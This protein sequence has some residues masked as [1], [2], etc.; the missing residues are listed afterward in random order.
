MEWIEVYKKEVFDGTNTTEWVDY[1]LVWR[2]FILVKMTVNSDK[3]YVFTES[4]KKYNDR[5]FS[6][7][8]LFLGRTDIEQVK[9]EIIKLFN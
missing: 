7:M 3:V 9:E 5:E 1:V 8:K 4:I 2:G 6:F